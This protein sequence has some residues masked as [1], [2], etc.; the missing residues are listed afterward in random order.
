MRPSFSCGAPAIAVHVSGDR[1]AKRVG[2]DCDCRP[3]QS[4]AVRERLLAD[5]GTLLSADLAAD[6]ERGEL[7]ANNNLAATDAKLVENAF[8]P[9]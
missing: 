7:T 3:A 6:W 2:I 8:E 9:S 5:S 4:A 1:G